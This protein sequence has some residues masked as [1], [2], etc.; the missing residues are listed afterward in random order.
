MRSSSPEYDEVILTDNSDDEEEEE[1]FSE[2]IPIK[3]ERPT[4]PSQ[5]ASDKDDGAVIFDDS[6][7]VEFNM[8]QVDWSSIDALLPDE[9][10]DEAPSSVHDKAGPDASGSCL[11]AAAESDITN[12]HQ[13]EVSNSAEML[14]AATVDKSEDYHVDISEGGVNISE[15]LVFDISS[16]SHLE[17]TLKAAE[18]SPVHSASRLSRKRSRVSKDESDERV[19]CK[20]LAHDVDMSTE[21]Q[22]SVEPIFPRPVQVDVGNDDADWVPSY[23]NLLTESSNEELLSEPASFATE[24][25]VTSSG[26]GT[27]IMFSQDYNA[28]FSQGT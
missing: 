10:T 16:V 11:S 28:S 19:Q 2:E 22:S 7:S 4:S 15:G 25:A 9:N 8:P 5:D 1:E 14:N 27:P 21:S 17:T 12:P 23:S 3:A 20:R 13:H 26:S 18:E 24:T 6:E